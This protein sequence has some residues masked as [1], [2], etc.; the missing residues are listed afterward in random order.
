MEFKKEINPMTPSARLIND[1]IYYY[2]NDRV[3]V[4]SHTRTVICY[5]TKKP[6]LKYH[7]RDRLCSD[8]LSFYEYCFPEPGMEFIEYK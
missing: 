1:L 7:Y 4:L 3:E 6:K 2:N 5:Y 8:V